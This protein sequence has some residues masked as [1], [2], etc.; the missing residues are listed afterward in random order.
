MTVGSNVNQNFPIP[1]IDQSSR[2]FR[3][4]FATIKQE[5]ENLQSKNIQVAGSLISEPVQI[6]NGTGDIIIPVDVTLAN[7]QAAGANL[8]VQYNF[9]GVISGSQIYYTNG[10]VGIGSTSPKQTLDIVGN[11]SVV[12]PSENTLI[13]LGS[14]FSIN[15]AS[16]TT[17][18]KSYGANVIVIDNINQTVGI[19]TIAT[20]QFEILSNTNDVARIKSLQNNQ[21]NTIRITT[22][23][24]N[25]TL[26]IAFEQTA[27]NRVGG[28]RM[29]QNGLVSIHAGEN[30]FAN[31]SNSSR[32]INIL[33]NHNVGIGSVSP[34]HTLDVAGNVAVSGHLTVGAVPTITGSIS[35]GAA[36]SNLLNALASMG[37]II[38]NTTP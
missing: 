14:A 9:N 5:I 7:I 34:Q 31:L 16:N 26:G 19:G 17:Q 37:L 20:S 33:P 12:S 4:N 6:G 15:S 2:G 22:D 28:L 35:S 29:D 1:G 11:I 18:F 36:V 10:T 8:S 32:V 30:M 27:S 3:D 13:K 21:D 24:N 23:V 25:S 38:N